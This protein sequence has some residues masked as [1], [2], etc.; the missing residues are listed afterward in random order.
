MKIIIQEE[1]RGIANPEAEQ[2]QNE[3]AE[4][5]KTLLSQLCEDCQ[6]VLTLFYFY[7]YSMKEIAEKLNYKNANVSKTKKR[8]CLKQLMT[9]AKEKYQK[10][11]F[12]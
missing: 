8:E 6:Q 9:L 11:D 7:E 3:Q 12:F 5:I 1:N 4:I 2:R 10:T